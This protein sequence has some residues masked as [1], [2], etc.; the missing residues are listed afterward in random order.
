MEIWRDQNRLHSAAVVLYDAVKS[1]GPRSPGFKLDDLVELKRKKSQCGSKREDEKF[2]CPDQTASTGNI[3]HSSDCRWHSKKN[4]EM[5][6][7]SGGLLTSVAMKR[8]VGGGYSVYCRYF[9]YVVKLL[10]PLKYV[11]QHDASCLAPSLSGISW[12]MSVKP[13][14]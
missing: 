3:G 13:Q 12:A 2:E 4:L 5:F 14:Q 1:C 11:C 7:S 9:I 8:D 10:S 6:W